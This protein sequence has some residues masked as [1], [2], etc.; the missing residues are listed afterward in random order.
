M[1]AA[2]APAAPDTVV[3]KGNRLQAPLPLYGAVAPEMG[4]EDR[5]Q[6]T[7]NAPRAVS[8]PLHNIAALG[9]YTDLEMLIAIAIDPS[10]NNDCLSRLS[11]RLF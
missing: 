3:V 8:L 1:D 7:N 11:S 9:T 2:P 6:R 10:S 4:C 5:P